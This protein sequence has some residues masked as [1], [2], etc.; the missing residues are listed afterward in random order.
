MT[1]YVRALEHISLSISEDGTGSEF[2]L[3]QKA[4]KVLPIW[5]AQQPG[6]QRLWAASKVQVA[7]DSAFTHV[8]TS[9]PASELPGYTSWTVLGDKPSNLVAGA[10]QANGY[11]TLDGAAKVPVAQL[12][13]AIMEYQGVYN[14]TTNTPALV[15][16]TG[17]SGDVY[18]VSVAGTKD[19][20]SGNVTLRVGDYIIYNGTIWQK[21]ATTDT[22]ASVAGLS[23]DVTAA[24]LAAALVSDNSDGTASTA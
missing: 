22:V 16:G 13:S 15:D 10:G 14:A 20:G 19:F 23:G 18:R 24:S 8:V 17:N 5:V 4:S 9:I 2:R 1:L 3:D 6:F 21:S 7:T 11:A 12:P